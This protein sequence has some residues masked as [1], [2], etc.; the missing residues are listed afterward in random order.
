MK[1]PKHGTVARYNSKKFTCRCIQCTIAIQSYQRNRRLNNPIAVQ[2]NREYMKKRQ[3]ETY[4]FLV[5]IKKNRPCIDCQV[6]YPHYVMH[7]DH[8]GIE[9]KLFNISR[10]MSLPREKILAEIAKC[11]LVCANCHAERTHTRLKKL[12]T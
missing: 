9:P 11:E 3:A 8:L 5:D 2:K 6:V 10:A 1:P 4:Q 12:L 7:W